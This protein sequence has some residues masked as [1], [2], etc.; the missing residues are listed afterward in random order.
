MA[1]ISHGK[2]ILVCY[3]TEDFAAGLTVVRV[4]RATEPVFAPV[5]DD[6]RRAAPKRLNLT[7]ADWLLPASAQT[8]R[9]ARRWNQVG[10]GHRLD[11]VWIVPAPAAGNAE[12]Y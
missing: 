7:K 1:A 2:T 8:V 12:F 9:D 11:L 5:G 3:R 6:V 4:R 10:D